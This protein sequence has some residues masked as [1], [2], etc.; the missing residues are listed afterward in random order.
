MT[1][2]LPPLS[3]EPVVDGTGLMNQEMR[4][5][6]EDVSN[7]YIRSGEGSPEGF[8]SARQATMYMDTNGTSGSILYIKKDD[9]VNGD[10]TLGWVLV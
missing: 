10:R 8:V 1:N 2:I 4:S 6:T 9:Q 7:L 3:I 5:W